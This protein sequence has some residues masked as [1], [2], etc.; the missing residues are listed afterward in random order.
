MSGVES[1]HFTLRE[2]FFLYLSASYLK[3]FCVFELRNLRLENKREAALGFVDVLEVKFSAIKDQFS[4]SMDSIWAR[5][6]NSVFWV[7]VDEP[8]PTGKRQL[9]EGVE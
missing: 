3:L 7:P 4:I 8:M 6:K 9:I 5:F 2:A 1:R